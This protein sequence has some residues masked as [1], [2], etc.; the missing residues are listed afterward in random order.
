MMN[1]L[2]CAMVRLTARD[3]ARTGYGDYLTVCELGNQHLKPTV[4]SKFKTR[5]VKKFY[6]KYNFTE[7]FAIDTNESCFSVPMD[8]N[9]NIKS[10]YN[11]NKQFDLVTNNGT[12]E[13]VFNQLSVF[14][15]MHDLCKLNGY[16]LHIL[17]FNSPEHGFYNFNPNLFGALALENNY[18]I[19]VSV[20]ATADM[21][22]YQPIEFTPNR[23]TKIVKEWNIPTDSYYSAECAVIMKKKSE[24]EFSI[25]MQEMY[26]KHI[27]SPEIRKNYK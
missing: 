9:Y 14:E 15:N 21:S 7:Y 25:P 26:V 23:Q 27:Q 24:K 10:K 4:K 18:E 6:Q 3:C 13:H 5:N 2:A 17:P 19:I 8:L 22:Y 11:F 20:I 12:G 16:M 1:L